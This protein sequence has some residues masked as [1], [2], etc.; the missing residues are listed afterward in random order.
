MLTY[1]IIFPANNCHCQ[2]AVDFSTGPEKVKNGWHNQ[3]CLFWR[4]VS[5]LVQ[6]CSES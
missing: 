6:D 4:T 5:L 1:P 2:K 3:L